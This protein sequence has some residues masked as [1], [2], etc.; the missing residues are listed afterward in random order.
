VAESYQAGVN[1][2]VIKPL[3]WEA[4]TEVVGQIGSYWL[5]VNQSTAS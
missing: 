4:L 2:Y 3:A 1:S 5:R